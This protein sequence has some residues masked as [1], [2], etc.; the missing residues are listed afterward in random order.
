M[1]NTEFVYTTFIRT[2]PQQLWK[3]LTQPEFT[4]QYWVE[5]IESDWEKGSPWVHHAGATPLGGV[6]LDSNPPHRLVM[7][8]ALLAE[9]PDASRHSRV[10]FD[11]EPMGDMVRLQVTHDR[12]Q[13]GS[14]M[15]GKIAVGWPRVL[16]SLKTLLETGAAL[17]TW[18]GHLDQ[19]SA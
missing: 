14:L 15:A 9:E 18:V 3:A 11:I 8:W 12:L 4:R 5:G 16:S 7:T 2:T 10:T 6:V 17:D 19:C 1:A 13:E